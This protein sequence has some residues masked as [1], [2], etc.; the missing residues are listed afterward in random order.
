MYFFLS[1]LIILFILGVC[2]L[3]DI[4]NEQ[5]SLRNEKILTNKPKIYSLSE[6]DQ[7]ALELDHSFKHLKAHK[8]NCNNQ[9]IISGFYIQPTNE[10]YTPELDP[11]HEYA[12]CMS[13]I[14]DSEI[15]QSVHY[16]SSSLAK[17]HQPFCQADVFQSTPFKQANVKKPKTF[18]NF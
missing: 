15:T 2:L 8:C 18:Q 9:T 6:A 12:N 13:T 1:S 11:T 7:S 14:E 10:I 4:L 17:V 3:K 5:K 16:C